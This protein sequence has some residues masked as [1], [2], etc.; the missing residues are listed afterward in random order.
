MRMPTLKA[1]THI[2]KGVRGI[3]KVTSMLLK[4]KKK[5][6]KTKPVDGIG[7]DEKKM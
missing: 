3:Q 1:I 5:K 7:T 2:R 6:K 4:K